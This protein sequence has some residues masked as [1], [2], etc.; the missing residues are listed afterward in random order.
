MN[1]KLKKVFAIASGLVPGVL[2]LIFGTNP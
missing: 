1:R 2:M